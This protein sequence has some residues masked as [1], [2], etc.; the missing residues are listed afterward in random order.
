MSTLISVAIPDHGRLRSLPNASRTFFTK[1]RTDK[2]FRIRCN[3][4]DFAAGNSA[5]VGRTG[6][7]GRCFYCAFSI[8]SSSLSGCSPSLSVEQNSGYQSGESCGDENSVDV[9]VD[10]VMA[11]RMGTFIQVEG[12]AE[13]A[14]VQVMWRCTKM[15]G[16]SPLIQ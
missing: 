10:R 9:G 12:E 14:G 5:A 11:T 8:L 2:V 3:C 7:T 15:M 16:I 6:L 4:A 1:W 13:D